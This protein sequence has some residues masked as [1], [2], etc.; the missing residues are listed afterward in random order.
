MQFN[1]DSKYKILSLKK[2]RIILSS[3]SGNF[4]RLIYK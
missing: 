2:D 1:L 4:K 3:N